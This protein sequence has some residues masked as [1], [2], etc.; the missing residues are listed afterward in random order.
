MNRQIKYYS[1]ND[2]ITLEVK[3]DIILDENTYYTI[4]ALE[5]LGKD[6]S[7][8]FDVNMNNVLAG[9]TYD[10]MNVIEKEIEKVKKTTTRKTKK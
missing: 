8:Y 7:D 9:D 6:R 10:K 1:G 3:Y 4:L 5:N 2:K